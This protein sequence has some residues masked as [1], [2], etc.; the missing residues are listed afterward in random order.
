MTTPKTKQ[1]APKPRSMLRA[2]TLTTL[3]LLASAC[4][5]TSPPTLTASAAPAPPALAALNPQARQ[6]IK[7]RYCWPSCSSALTAERENWR[8]QLTTPASAAPPA[9]ASTTAPEN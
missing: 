1:R 2:A 5:Q 9:S 4:A 3:A 6:G 7:P 8:K